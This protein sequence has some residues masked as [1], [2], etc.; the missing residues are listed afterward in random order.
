MAINNFTTVEIDGSGALK[1]QGQTLDSKTGLKPT[2]GIDPNTQIRVAVISCDPA[3]GKRCY[4]TVHAPAS[5]SWLGLAPAGTHEFHNHDVVYAIGH[6][7]V[8][9][10]DEID[11]WCAQV[12]IGDPQPLAESDTNPFG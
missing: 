9:P 3:E 8:P 7:T 4:P 11:L 12:R 6:L 5:G 2:H 10:S 1:V